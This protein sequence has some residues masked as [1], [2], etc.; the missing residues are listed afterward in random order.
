MP[1][2]NINTILKNG[3]AAKVKI[4]DYSSP[5]QIEKLKKLKKKSDQVLKNKE[6]DPE[7]LRRIYINR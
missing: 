5:E 4:I 2:T 7:K 6:S 1:K 3:A